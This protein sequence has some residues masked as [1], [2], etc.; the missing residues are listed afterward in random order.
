MFASVLARAINTSTCGGLPVLFLPP[1]LLHVP[2]PVPASCAFY[3]IC[4]NLLFL[5]FPFKT[6][7]GLGLPP[8]LYCIFLC[9]QLPFPG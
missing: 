3:K 4:W 8:F 9:W 7:L 6:A 2:Y 5:T 1:Q